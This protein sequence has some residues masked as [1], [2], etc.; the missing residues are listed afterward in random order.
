[1]KFQSTSQIQFCVLALCIAALPIS[2]STASSDD[3]DFDWFEED[4]EARALEVNEGELRFLVKLPDKPV[5]HHDN[6]ITLNAE[7]LQDGWV[8]LRQCHYNIDK[9][10][11]AQILFREGRIRNLR[12]T[13]S[14][15]IGKTWVEGASVQ[16]TDINHDS[17][18][19]IEAESLVLT[20]GEDGQYRINNGPYMRRFL[21][22]YYPMQVTMQVKLADSGLRF[23]SIKPERQPGFSVEDTA[24]SIR[25]EAWFEGRL[26]TEIGLTPEN[27]PVAVLPP[28][29]LSP[30]VLNPEAPVKRF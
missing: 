14:K 19:C 26:R 5:H 15:N 11:R 13:E 17:S 27:S 23:T 10:S 22:G 7:S 8:G 20:A 2:S 24:D 3:D 16:L 18:L 12:I 6:V 21:D 25:F 9:V 1:M 30:T 29:R 28:G 4:F